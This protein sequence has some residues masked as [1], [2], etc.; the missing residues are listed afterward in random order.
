VEHWDRTAVRSGDAPGFIVNRVNRPFTIEAL[1]ML[2]AAEASVAAIDGALK[3]DG[4]PMGPFELIDLAG[5]D[6]N[7]AAARAVWEGLGRPDRLRPSPIQERLLADGRLGR[8]SGA[9]FYAYGTSEPTVADEFAGGRSRL[10]PGD[11]LERILLAVV[12]EAW[13]ALGEGVAGRDDI[14]VALKLGAAH[15]VGPFERTERLGG[16]PAVVARL[17]ALGREP[18]PA[19]LGP[20]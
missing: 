20:G 4:F 3:L 7:L 12:D 18:A 8:K 19:L 1:R 6:V 9:G 15:P 5:V 17:R 2:E 14:E 10:E 13:H 16:R 11:I